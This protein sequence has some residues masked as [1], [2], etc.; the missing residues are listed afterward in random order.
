MTERG[1]TWALRLGEVAGD[2]LPDAGGQAAR[3]TVL[4]RVLHTK[5]CF[6]ARPQ[7]AALQCLW[8]KREGLW[9]TWVPGLGGQEQSPVTREVRALETVRKPPT[10]REACELACPTEGHFC[11]LPAGE[12]G[13]IET[14]RTKPHSPLTNPNRATQS[15]G[16]SNLGSHG[17][18]RGHLNP[19][20]WE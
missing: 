9:G 6:Q 7:D 11:V 14:Q 18:S 10:W 8:G 1:G 15:V 17:A 19:Q 16:V 20:I 12:G 13:P 3:L 5:G 2:N 4:G